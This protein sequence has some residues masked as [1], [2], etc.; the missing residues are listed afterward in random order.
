MVVARGRRISE[1]TVSK[2]ELKELKRDMSN[3]WTG[4]LSDSAIDD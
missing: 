2:A 3:F 1:V 4:D